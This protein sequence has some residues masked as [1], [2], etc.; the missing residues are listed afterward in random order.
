MRYVR[1]ETK[2]SEKKYGVLIEDKVKVVQGSI[3]EDH[4]I[5]EEKYLLETVKLLAPVEP[6][7]VLCIGLNYIDHAEEFGK[8]VPPEPLLFLKPSTSVIGPNERIIYPPQTQNLHYEVELTMVIGKIAKNV[9]RSEALGHVFGYTVGNDI[10]ARDLQKKDNQWS[11]AK[12]FDTFCPLGPWVETEI[13]NPD[14]LKIELYLNGETR[15]QSNTHNMVFKCAELIEYLSS[16]MTLLPGDVIL[17]GTPGGI[18]AM[19]PGDLVEA[20]VEG[21]GTLKNVVAVPKQE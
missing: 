14:N 12:G 10:T 5:S 2:T 7:K 9:K 19:Q 16:I 8:P 21:I 11:R 17:T 3:F 6:S 4:T 13:E 15:Q 20:Y 1:F 18:G